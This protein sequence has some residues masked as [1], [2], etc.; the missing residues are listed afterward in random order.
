[1][2]FLW[3]VPALLIFIPEGVHATKSSEWN[4]GVAGGINYYQPALGGAQLEGTSTSGVPVFMMNVFAE[5]STEL[6]FLVD[7]GAFY[8][9]RKYNVS[10]AEVSQNYTSVGASF[11]I[12]FDLGPFS[13]KAGAFVASILSKL[14]TTGT[15]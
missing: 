7:F 14:E 15:A 12:G 3:A 6:G 2:K 5:R 1:M 4:I 10:P 9:N 8:E 13:L 11:Q